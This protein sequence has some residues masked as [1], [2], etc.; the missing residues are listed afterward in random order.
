[1]IRQRNRILWLLFIPLWLVACAT[2]DVPSTPPP[3][4]TVPAPPTLVPSGNCDLTP[5][6]ESW[7]QTTV[8][9]RDEFLALLDTAVA[10][11][12]A[13]AYEDVL[14]MVDRRN[15]VSATPYPDCASE[16]HLLLVD[17]MSKAVEEFQKYVN[18]ESVDV[19]RVVADTKT[20]I[21]V[22][23][24]IQDDLIKRMDEQ[25]KKP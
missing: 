3:P 11:D 24:V 18:G 12:R 2:G 16:A 7:L 21:E 4:L 13:K 5:Q 25:Y 1:M 19:T 20:K 6:L 9:M 23:K 17:A 22:V 8:F 14:G 10:K 15:R